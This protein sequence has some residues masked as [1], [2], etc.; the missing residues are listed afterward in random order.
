[1]AQHKTVRCNEQTTA[2]KCNRRLKDEFGGRC[3]QVRGADK[4]M[5]HLMFGIIALC[6]DQLIKVT[7]C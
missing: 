4:V 7:G 1:M 6:A 5:L 3:V 2:E